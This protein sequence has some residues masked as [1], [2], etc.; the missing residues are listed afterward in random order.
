MAQ[1]NTPSASNTPGGRDG[2][3]TWTDAS[4]NLWLFGGGGF[5]ASGNSG[6]LNDLWE[7]TPTTME[8]AWV[9]GSSTVPA[10]NQGRSGVYSTVGSA[11]SEAVPGGRQA[12][13]SWTDASGNLWLFG[14][15]GFDSNGVNGDLNDLWKYA[16][17]SQ[18]WTWVDG[19]NTVPA[20]GNGRAGVYGTLGAPAQA[21]IPGGRWGA[22]SWTDQNGNL[23]LF[24][25]VGF[26]S[27]GASG[28]LNDL[29]QFNPATAQWAWMAGSST[30]GSNG[31]QYGVYGT[32]GTAASGNEPSSRNQAVTWTDPSGNLWLFG[33]YGYDSTGTWGYL[34]DLWQFN[35]SS[36]QWAWMGGSNT[37][38]CAGCGQA[39]VYGTIGTRDSSSQPG[40]RNQAVGWTDA[41]GNLWMFGGV[42][43]DSNGVNG[44]LNDLWEYGLSSGQWAWVGGSNTVPASGKGQPGNYGSRGVPSNSDNPGGRWSSGAWTDQHGDLWLFG[45]AGYDANGNYDNLNDL[46]V[47][48][49]NPGT[50]ATATPTLSIGSG[51][52]TGAQSITI[53]DQLP[54]ATIYYTTDGSAPTTGSAVYTG[55]ITVGSAETIQAIAL[56]SGYGPSGMASASYTIV[57][58]FSLGLG[59]GA[60]SITVYPG[61]TANF[62]LILTPV[63][64]S[65]F[66]TA[67]TF[68]ATGL[69]AGATAT[70]SPST[71]NA[72]AGATNVTFAVQT[73]SE[74]P[75]AA[76]L[77]QPG[78]NRNQPGSLT[79]GLLCLLF[80]PLAAVA[81]WRKTAKHLAR[82]ASLMIWLLILAGITA[83]ATGCGG[84][85]SINSN[86]VAAPPASYNI[87]ITAKSGAMQ[88]ST[89]VTVNIR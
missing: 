71:V 27:T 16:P 57:A 48:Q 53:A 52:Y 88:K 80:L 87:T 5:D 51:T 78:K 65:T 70:F 18:E 22:N 17:S 1:L 40:G 67:I 72:G 45:G 37:V 81:R 38:G 29:W 85:A 82:H 64:G 84:G 33:G 28:S 4:G 21:N 50:L 54:G 20:A 8:W 12:S 59:T 63:G 9:G 31:G 13:V 77:H 11:S 41:S 61:G 44:D 62:N 60:S 34:N 19:G 46:W 26:D 83:A 58:P 6:Y 23:W 76:M 7:F 3:V 89:A 66:P 43:F 2:S 73:Q 39:G 55:P 79:G 36:H 74:S 14:G 35:S 86:A 24:G 68:T 69:P 15:E 75:A 10:T 56:A 32:V 47:Y 49:P 30:V 25:G 42:G